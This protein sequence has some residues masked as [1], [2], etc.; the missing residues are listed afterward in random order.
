MA[1][2]MVKIVK[3]TDDSGMWFPACGGTE[4]PFLTK[5]GKTLL[6]C[7]NPLFGQHAYLDVRADIFLTNDEADAAMGNI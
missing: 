4:T 3:R 5:S 6:Y 7:Y 2:K 1:E